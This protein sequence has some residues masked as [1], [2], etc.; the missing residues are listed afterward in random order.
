M[1]KIKT[2]E[3][4]S[5]HDALKIT[6]KP[7]AWALCYWMRKWNDNPATRNKVRRLRGYVEKS[8]LISALEEAEA[9]FNRSGQEAQAFVNQQVFGRTRAART[10]QT[11]QKG[12]IPS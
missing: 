8:S 10:T 9:I 11:L 1:A 2:P 6:G 3:W 4:I 5:H 12:G 7:S